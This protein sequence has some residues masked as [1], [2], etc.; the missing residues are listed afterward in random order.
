M[1]KKS[2]SAFGIVLLSLLLACLGS[3]G[4]LGMYGLDQTNHSFKEIY[5][6]RVVLMG[7]LG[8][9]LDRIQQER[10]AAVISV[11]GRNA[12]KVKEQKKTIQQLD[13]EIINVW[14]KYMATKLT[15]EEIKLAEDFKH[16]WKLF[17][18]SYNHTMTLAAD[19]DY[20]AA[21]IILNTDTKLKFEPLYVTMLRLLE[22]QRNVKVAEYS[23]SED[24]YQDIFGITLLMMV[25]GI[26]STLFVG[27]ILLRGNTNSVKDIA[28][29]VRTDSSG[30]SINCKAISKNKTDRLVYTLKALN[31]KLIDLVCSVPINLYKF[32]TAVSTENDTTPAARQEFENAHNQDSEKIAEHIDAIKSIVLQTTALALNE[33]HAHT[34]TDEKEH[35]VK[36]SI[37]KSDTLRQDYEVASGKIREVINNLNHGVRKIKEDNDLADVQTNMANLSEIVSEIFSIMQISRA[38]AEQPVYLAQQI[39]ETEQQKAILPEEQIAVKS[40]T[41]SEDGSLKDTAILTVVNNRWNKFNCKNN[42]LE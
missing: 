7:D 3:I 16:L 12:E 25:M 41:N 42:S 17:M 27:F 10:L 38:S 2:Q 24:R 19:G 40:I 29:V 11:Y 36:V 33:I 26:L 4:S 13:A 28:L 30:T 31:S 37:A 20:D 1:Q 22:L 15:V 5:K 32:S 6:D 35:G 8:L 21:M 18:D 14:Q 9:I 34:Q 23:A 39:N